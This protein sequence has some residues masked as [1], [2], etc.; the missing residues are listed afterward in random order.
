MY[1]GKV[2]IKNKDIL[3]ILVNGKLLNKKKNT[4]Y[5][6]YC[7]SNCFQEAKKQVKSSCIIHKIRKLYII[8]RKS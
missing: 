8:K 1:V 2:T 7:Q 4:S 3:K 5:S 6:D